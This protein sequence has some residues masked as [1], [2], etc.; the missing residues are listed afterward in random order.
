M[1]QRLLLSGLSLLLNPECSFK[2]NVQNMSN[3]SSDRRIAAVSNI[4]A[5]KVDTPLIWLSPAPTRASTQSTTL[6][7][8]SSHGTKQPICAISTITPTWRMYVDLPPIFGPK[9]I[10]KKGFYHNDYGLMH[11][12]TWNC[13]FIIL[14]SNKSLPV[15]IWNISSPLVKVT[16]LGMKATS[17]WASTQGCLAAFTMSLPDPFSSILGLM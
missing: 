9:N 17:S 3:L 12:C 5:I 11:L 10:R 2:N 8:A 16:S 4:S 6:N 14:L 13:Y 7:S 1:T 15:M